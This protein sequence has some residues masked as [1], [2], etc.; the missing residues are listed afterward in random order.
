MAE[1]IMQLATQDYFSLDD[2]MN[3][4]LTFMV[5]SS[6]HPGKSITFRQLLNTDLLYVIAL[7]TYFHFWEGEYKGPS[8]GLNTFLQNYLAIGEANFH[9]DKNFIH[10]ALGDKLLAQ[11]YLLK[12]FFYIVFSI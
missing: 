1:A 9:K 4:F 12:I 3:S 5:R 8:T 2:D 6:F 10:A 11:Q 7:I